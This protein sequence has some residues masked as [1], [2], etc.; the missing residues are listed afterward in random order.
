MTILGVNELARNLQRIAARVTGEA[1]SALLA[2]GAVAMKE[3]QRRTPVEEGDL[4]DS[5][6]LIGPKVSGGVISVIIRAGGPKA[7]H[8]AAV[9]E[10]LSARHDDGRAKFME[11]TVLESRQRLGRDLAGRINLKRLA[12]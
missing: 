2:E 3:S 7:P 1:G 9:H 4:R 12:R 10:D 11:S 8:G 6:E 5:H